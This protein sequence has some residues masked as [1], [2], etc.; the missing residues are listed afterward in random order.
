MFKSMGRSFFQTVGD[1]SKGTELKKVIA[2]K[3]RDKKWKSGLSDNELIELAYRLDSGPIYHAVARLLSPEKRK[4]VFP[5]KSLYETGEDLDEIAPS[6]SPGVGT[7]TT[8]AN[9]AKYAVPLGSNPPWMNL[10]RKK[11]KRK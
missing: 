7:T 5:D 4:D 9:V 6:G 10:Q 1:D 2:D 8:T 3:L 11:K